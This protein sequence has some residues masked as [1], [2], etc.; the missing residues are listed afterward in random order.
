MIAWLAGESWRREVF[1]RGGDI[2]CA[3]ASAMFHVPV[4]KHGVNGHLRQK[5]KIAELALGYGG[6]VGALKAMGA[7]EMGVPE[8][9]LQP[10]VDAWRRA[11]P[12]I[13][14]LW[15]NV[16]RAVKTAIR[17]K[18]TVQL[19]NLKFS[20]RSG[21]LFIELPSGR[22]LSYPQPRL[23]ENKF[24]GES[25]CYMGPGPTRRWEQI[26]SYG[27]KFVENIVQ[28]ISRDLLVHAMFQLQSDPK[29]TVP[30]GSSDPKRTVPLGSLDIVAHVHDEVILETDP[31]VTA[32]EISL[33]MSITPP[34]AEGLLLRAEGYECNY[35]RKE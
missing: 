14:R 7:L 20:C 31:A 29:R 22:S 5:G 35:Y 4:E 8:N 23:C 3:S 17:Q 32:E 30:L 19:F 21:M 16:D 26:E 18:T 9:E 11:N 10:L 1:A 25:V 28:G 33:K 24:G 27:P 6:G 15:W 13:V 12:N 2:Y 34:W